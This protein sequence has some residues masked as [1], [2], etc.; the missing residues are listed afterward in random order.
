M[1]QFL[2]VIVVWRRWSL[3]LLEKCFQSFFLSKSGNGCFCYAHVYGITWLFY[4][5][6]KGIKIAVT[7]VSV[8]LRTK[9]FF[10]SA[11]LS[12]DQWFSFY[13]IN[14]AWQ[15]HGGL[16]P[17]SAV[18]LSCVEVS[19]VFEL[20]FEQHYCFGS[21]SQISCFQWKSSDAPTVHDQPRTKWQER[22]ATK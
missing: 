7:F 20:S 9:T 3:W 16:S 4:C 6:K 1:S 19:S 18:P 14:S 8:I 12:Y 11:L 22:F 5:Y 15:T 10:S 2:S 17:S 21:L 13:F